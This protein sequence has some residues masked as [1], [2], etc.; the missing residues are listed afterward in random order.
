MDVLYIDM[1]VSTFAHP[2]T[3]QVAAFWISLLPVV[4]MVGLMIGALVRGD[5]GRPRLSHIRVPN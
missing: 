5:R 3:T 2:Y 4:S 1:V